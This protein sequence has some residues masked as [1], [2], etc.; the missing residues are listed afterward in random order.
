MKRFNGLKLKT[1]LLSG[2][3]ALAMLAG[4]IGYVGITG[5]QRVNKAD[6]YLYENMTAPM[7]HLVALTDNYQKY[8]VNVR[9]LL[10]TEDSLD[11]VQ[12]NAEIER[13]KEEVR[14]A[15]AAYEKT[16]TTDEGRQMLERFTKGFETLMPLQDAAAAL[17]AQNRNAEGYAALLEAI[18]AGKEVESALDEMAAQKVGRAKTI[19]EENTALTSRSVLLMM[20]MI[21]LG[22]MAALLLGGFIARAIG[23]PVS[24]LEAAA[25][26]IAAGDLSVSVEES[27]KDEIGNLSRSF[28]VMVRNIREA[29]AAV[30]AEKA[31]VEQKVADGIRAA[32]QDAA[33]M[34]GVADRYGWMIERLAEGDLMARLSPEGYRK[35]EQDLFLAFN[36]AVEN[37]STMIRQVSMAAGSAAGAS[38]QISASSEQLATSA[39][40]QS[41]QAGE[42][43]AAV[44]EMVRTI[45]DNSRNAQQAS[46]VASNAGALAREGGAVVRETVDKIRSIAGVVKASAHTVEQLGASSQKI[47][48]IVSVINDIADQTN[49]LALNAAIEAARAGDQGR[50]FAVVADEVRKLA[51]RTT[52]ATKEIAGMI[53]SIQAE[54]QEVVLTMQRG[55]EEVSEGIYLADQAGAAL[56]KVVKGAADTVDMVAQIAAATEEQ[57]STSEQIARS[58]DTISNVTLESA[59][60]V[61]QIARSAESLSRLTDE[62]HEMVSRFRTEDAA[63]SASA[64]PHHDA[65]RTFG[66]GHGSAVYPAFQVARRS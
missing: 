42:V 25:A 43:A 27:G 44:E 30:Q 50:G 1:K 66:D 19:A 23:G 6:V 61:G 28:N 10:L 45:V 7:E 49:L 41:A 63:V 36:R 54:T 55:S 2:F 59:Q 14:N 32:E 48:D 38:T 58:V 24:K 8:R 53:K 18:P 13:L 56:E 34:Q 17:G 21:A 52:Q 37:M 46:E 40:E 33:Y 16:L 62:L 29:N 12:L 65:A 35:A 31:G 15:S 9:G 20:V 22:I 51:E 4:I 64:A 57:S 11:N 3:I 47:G 26:G 60:G 39:Q 5:I